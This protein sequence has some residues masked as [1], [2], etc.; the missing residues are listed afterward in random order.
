MSSS[1][2]SAS[3]FNCPAAT[4]TGVWRLPRWYA[5]RVRVIGSWACTTSTSCG[6]AITR[7]RPPSSATSMSPSRSTV[8]RGSTSATSSPLSSVAARRL[9]QRSSKGRV[10]VGARLISGAASFASIRLSIVRMKV[11]EKEVALRHWQDGCRLAGEQLAVGY[12]LIRF[13]IDSNGRHVRIVNHVGLRDIPAIFHRYHLLLQSIPF[14]DT[15]IQRHLRDERQ[16][17][18]SQRAAAGREHLA[19]MYRLRRRD[20][21]VRV[22]HLRD[23]DHAAFQDHCRLH[24]EERGFPED[25]IRPFSRLDGPH[26]MRDAMRDRRIDRVLSDVAFRAEI[27]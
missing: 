24:T 20:R 10:S 18:L 9:L 11:S 15:V 22:T 13:R 23:R 1:T 4:S 17:G 6:A 3:S 21:C 8:P 26:F 12:H 2:G 5:A 25:E 19:I 16:R 14:A 27:V 7:T